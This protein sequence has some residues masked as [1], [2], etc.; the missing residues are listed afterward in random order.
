MFMSHS[1]KDSYLSMEQANSEDKNPRQDNSRYSSINDEEQVAT[2]RGSITKNNMP[3]T[4]N[5]KK[6]GSF[7]K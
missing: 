5:F 4:G 3:A 7:S 6:S 1:K 2:N